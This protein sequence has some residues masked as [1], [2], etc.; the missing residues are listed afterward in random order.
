MPLRILR[1]FFIRKILDERFSLS[2]LQEWKTNDPQWWNSD[3]NEMG[4]GFY[5]EAMRER[6]RLEAAP[7]GELIA[8]LTDIGALGPPPRLGR[9]GG[10]PA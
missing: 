1:A 5:G 6:E 3:R 4:R 8:E 10:T 9:A 2:A 7:E